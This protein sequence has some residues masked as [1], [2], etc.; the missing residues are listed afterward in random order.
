[1]IK[2]KGSMQGGVKVECGLNGFSSK[3][4][5]KNSKQQHANHVAM[6]TGLHSPL[7]VGATVELLGVSECS[8]N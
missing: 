5:M 7:A 1:M 6:S 2:A 3:R 8:N 4:E